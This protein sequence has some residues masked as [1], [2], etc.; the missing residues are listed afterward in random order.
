MDILLLDDS[1]VSLA[2]GEATEEFRQ[3]FCHVSPLKPERGG[4]RLFWEAHLFKT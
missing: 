2:I 1:R 3:V 4:R